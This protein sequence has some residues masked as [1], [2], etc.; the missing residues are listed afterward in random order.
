[1]FFENPVSVFSSIF[2]QA[3]H[4]F[5][6]EDFTGRCAN[7]NYTK[8]TCLWVGNGFVMLPASK[9]ITLGELDNRIYTAAPSPERANFRSATPTGF[10]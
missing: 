9:D 1:M 3:D 4:T 6:P 8:K 10:A 2:G 7:D 5:S